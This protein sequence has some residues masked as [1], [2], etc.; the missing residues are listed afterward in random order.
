MSLEQKILD[1]KIIAIDTETTGLNPWT[2]DMPFGIS[3]LTG[4]GDALYFQWHV[5]PRTRQVIPDR[6]ELRFCKKILTNPAVTKVFFHAKFDIRMMEVAYGI[7]TVLPIE[8]VMFMGFIYNT[9]EPSFKLKNLAKKYLDI[10]NDDETTLKKATISARR[11]AKKLGWKIAEDVEADYWLPQKFD[12]RN[13]LCK[14][15]CIIDTERTMLLRDFYWKYA[16]VERQHMKKTYEKEMT[17]WPIIYAMESRGVAVDLNTIDQEIKFHDQKAKYWMQELEKYAG[18]GFNPNSSK[19]LIDLF[20]KKMKLKI[21][22]YTDKG[23]PKVNDEALKPHMDKPVMRAL[24]KYRASSKA[25]NNFFERYK[26]LSVPDPI[27]PGYVLHANF[28]QARA[29]TARLACKTPN[30]Q[31]VPNVAITGSIEPVEARR[32]FG[33]R[34]GYVWY[35]FDFAQ[36]EARIFASNSNDELMLEAFKTGKDVFSE[37]ENKLWG[38]ETTIGIRT[39]MHLLELDGTGQEDQ[40]LVKAIWK[41][42]G[43]KK[44]ATLSSTDKKKI[45]SD[46][47]SKFNWEVVAAERSLDKGIYRSMTKRIFYLN[48]YGG[49]NKA[50]MTQLGCDEITARAT[51]KQF[52]AAF[53]NIAIYQKEMIAQASANGYI[54]NSYDRRLTVK[55]YKAYCAINYMTQ[56][57]AA[58]LLKIGMIY[59]DR[60]L[61]EIDLDINLIL[62]VHDE[63]IYEVN[64]RHIFKSVLFE[65]KR[66]MEDIDGVFKIEIP[67][68]IEICRKRWDKVE[69]LKW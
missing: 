23:N 56:G 43:I 12:R 67:I 51:F 42:Y 33:P 1:A 35:H 61:K 11:K 13:H 49:G 54:V 36:M 52:D 66:L 29:A 63:S 2:G 38:G 30:F 32:P 47:L 28:Q 62:S 3:F 46:W 6:E 50:M 17:L 16:A 18:K 9:L 22:Y 34:Y 26:R 20:Y 64:K 25:N 10:N 59:C 7:H 69:K 19:Q 5:Q 55:R 41:K 58:D 45:V 68:D 15:Y 40:P 21:H 4:D 60:Y 53:P 37:M 48:I 24:F 14:K 27:G 39:G 57:D 44:V 8:E 31:N 65:L